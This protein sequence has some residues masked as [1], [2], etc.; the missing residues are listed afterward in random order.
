VLAAVATQL[1][2]AVE[3]KRLQKE[4]LEAAVL[5]LSDELKTSLLNAVSHD[6]RT[7]LASIVASA[8]SLRQDDVTWTLD[9]RR[10][11]VDTI[12]HEAER[13][14]AI[15]ENLLDVSRMQSGTLRPK[16]AWYDLGA[17]VDDVLGRLRP[18]TAAHD[19]VVDIPEDLSP[20]E[21]DY[22]EID[23]V[24]SNLIENAAKYVPPGR[25][26]R[27]SAR[28]AAGELRV[29]VADRGPG[30]SP[31]SLQRLFEAFYR[32]NDGT[33]RSTRGS[34]LGL[35]IAKGLVEAHGGK[36]WAENRVGGG[37]R[38]VFTLPARDPAASS[39][40]A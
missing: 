37:A 39:E 8:G 28:R 11:F 10:E 20:V 18:V 3:R 21:L 35:A 9:D 31:G 25:E 30:L 38:F 26:I 6:L 13:L 4:A 1:G 36:I 5:R 23:Q 17:L 32:D 34:G 33:S 27:I 22:V 7:P 15:I 19:V 14:N 40:R 29:E 2:Q 16:K 12:Q 24:L